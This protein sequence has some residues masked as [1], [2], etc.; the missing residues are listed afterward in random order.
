L[1]HASVAGSFST[2]KISSQRP[3]SAKAIVFPPAPAKASMSVRFV[4]G[5]TSASWEAILL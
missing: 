4:L 2:A 1:A 3:L 5:V